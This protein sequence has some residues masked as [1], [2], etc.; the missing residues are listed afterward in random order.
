[1]PVSRVY[2]PPIFTYV[3]MYNIVHDNTMVFVVYSVFSVYRV[4]SNA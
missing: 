1:M 4:Y 2:D 3:Y